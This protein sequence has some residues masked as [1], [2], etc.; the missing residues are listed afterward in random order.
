[1][2]FSERLYARYP[3]LRR[4]RL[5]HIERH[6]LTISF[7]FGFVVDALTLRRVDQLFDNLVLAWYILLAMGSMVALYAATAGKLSEKYGRSVRDWS[8]LVI[9]YALGGL[10]SG[11]LIFY[12][13]SG[14]WLASWPF[15]I[16]ILAVMVGNERL[17]RRAE[18]LLLNLVMLFVGIFSYAALIVP[19]ILGKIGA[20]I[21]LLAGALACALMYGFVRLLSRVVPNFMQANMR[22]AVFALASVY[23]ALNVL[24]FTNIIP[25]IPLSLTALGVYHSVERLPDGNYALIYE[26]GPWYHLFKASDTTFHYQAGDTIYCFAS[27]FAPTRLSTE[28]FHRW[29]YYDES[30]G[31]WQTHG[32]FAYGIGGGRDEGYRGYTA[33]TRVQEGKWR[34]SV[35]TA[36]GQVLGRDTFRVV[37]G[38][39]PRGLVNEVR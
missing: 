25:P 21:F 30:A 29:E 20:W 11:M 4:L 33:I 23:F 18:R 31:K 22:A 27:V 36:R 13:K 28:I 19:V 1:M 8:P 34:C 16:L 17:T 12:S 2:D 7:F 3:S 10:A 9:Q 15:L 39:V 24:Y 35:E 5:H 37:S 14:S 38:A 32:R 26:Q 6:W